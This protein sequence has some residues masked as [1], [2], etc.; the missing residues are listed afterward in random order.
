M[1]NRSKIDPKLCPGGTW[2]VPRGL[3]GASRGAVGH[4][5]RCN[6]QLM[7]ILKDSGRLPGR[8]GRPL[9]TQRD[10]K[11]RPQN[12]FLLKNGVPNVDFP[13]FLCARPLFR[14]CA[15]FVPVFF[16]KNQWK[17]NEKT[18]YFFTVSLVFLNVATLTKHCILRYE[19]YF[20]IFCVL[21]FCF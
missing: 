16:A 18:M 7:K 9:G 3:P 4:A 1:K 14:L 13:R 8:P 15:R 11:N 6:W 19:S 12:D 21:A 20:S 2:G 5:V 10:A 17:F